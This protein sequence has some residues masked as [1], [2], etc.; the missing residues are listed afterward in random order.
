MGQLVHQGER[1]GGPRVAIVDNDEGGDVV[2]QCK[3]TKSLQVDRG[4]IAAQVAD[5]EDID[6]HLLHPIAEQCERFGNRALR[7][8]FIEVDGHGCTDGLDDA[9]HPI[10]H[11]AGSDEVDAFRFLLLLE[12]RTNQALARLNIS[13]QGVEQSLVDGGL[14]GRQRAEVLT[15]VS[16]AR[17]LRQVKREQ[18]TSILFR[19]LDQHGASGFDIAEFELSQP[20]DGRFSARLPNGELQGGLFQRQTGSFPSPAKNVRIYVRHR[21]SKDK[22]CVWRLLA[23]LGALRSSPAIDRSLQRGDGHDPEE[24]FAPDTTGDG[25][26]NAVS[27]PPDAAS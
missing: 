24:T 27:P 5:E 9:R 19:H 26:E 15:P 25:H 22:R 23:S 2:G 7:P 16:A 10:L 11:S 20:L 18:R 1:P 17:R 4:V 8:E 3:A 13:N 6:A 21:L 14:I 12:H